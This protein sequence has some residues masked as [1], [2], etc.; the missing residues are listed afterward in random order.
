MSVR[1]SSYLLV[2]IS[3]CL[4]V[5]HLLKRFSFFSETAFKRN[6]STG[7]RILMTV[8]YH[9]FRHYSRVDET[10]VRAIIDAVWDEMILW[11]TNHPNAHKTIQKNVAWINVCRKTGRN[12]TDSKFTI[13]LALWNKP[14][15]NFRYFYFI[16][17]KSM[18]NWTYTNKIIVQI[19]QKLPIFITS[20]VVTNLQN[21]DYDNIVQKMSS[22]NY[23]S[24]NWADITKYFNIF[25]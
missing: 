22:D 9:Y 12:V 21:S 16:I 20:Q 7:L 24:H 6:H 1:G 19:Y 11:K 5:S 23:S 18:I 25:S 8:Y 3:A 2:Y 17:R 14:W 10:L 4:A 15:V 13:L